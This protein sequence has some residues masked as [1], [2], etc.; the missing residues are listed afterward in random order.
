MTSRTLTIFAGA[1]LLTLAACRTDVAAPLDD[2]AER[3][4]L[5]QRTLDLKASVAA[6]G[7]LTPEQARQLD[8][9][10]GRIRAWQARTGRTDLAISAP[11]PVNALV[12]RDPG[13]SPVCSPCPTMKFETGRICFYIGETPCQPNAPIV[14]MCFYSCVYIGT[15]PRR[16]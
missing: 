1:L 16:G 5:V 4:Q 13:A 11:P 3:A 2:D 6:T 14:Q 15:P 8:D 10:A 7:R 12:A 9:L